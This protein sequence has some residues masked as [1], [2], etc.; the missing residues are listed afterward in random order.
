MSSGSHDDTFHSTV[1]YLQTDAYLAG[2]IVG[3]ANVGLFKGFLY[4]EHGGEI[5]FH[6]S[7]ILLDPLEGRQPNPGGASKLAL[8]PA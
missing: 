7:F 1:A 2:F 3:E 6:D 4:L 8:A 5:S